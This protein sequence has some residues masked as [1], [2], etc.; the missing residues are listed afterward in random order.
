M[1]S[2]LVSALVVCELGRP[3]CRRVVH[4]CPECGQGSVWDLDE[5]TRGAIEVEVD[6][7]QE[8]DQTGCQQERRQTA[9]EQTHVQPDQKHRTGGAD[10]FE[11]EHLGWDAV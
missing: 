1:S 6:E 9:T 8:R 11:Q 7:E 5:T 3:V 4:G 10:H 2:W